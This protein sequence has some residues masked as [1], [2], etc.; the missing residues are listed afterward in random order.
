MD[1]CKNLE[2]GGSEIFLIVEEEERYEG[3]DEHAEKKRVK[4]KGV[5]NNAPRDPPPGSP[6]RGLPL[7]THVMG[8]GGV[9]GRTDNGDA[10]AE[11]DLHDEK[12]HL[13]INEE[14]EQTAECGLLGSGTRK[15]ISII[16]S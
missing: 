5:G 11:D 6:V 16:S 9:E 1:W 3:G 2:S 8:I 12:S 4:T 13:R 14:I 10:N 7:R 15:T